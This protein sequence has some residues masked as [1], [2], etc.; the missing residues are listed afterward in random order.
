[1][2]SCALSR[3]ALGPNASAI[4]AHNPGT[5]GETDPCPGVFT[6]TMQTLKDSK[7]AFGISGIESDPIIRDRENPL[8]ARRLCGNLHDRSHILLS[9]LQSVSD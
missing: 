3:F 5:D 9:V 8:I 2:E 7:N 1:M 4:V 6:M